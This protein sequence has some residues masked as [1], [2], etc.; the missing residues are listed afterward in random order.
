MRCIGT[1][2]VGEDVSS[3]AEAI[4]ASFDGRLIMAPMPGVARVWL[5]VP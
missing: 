3:C 1:R 5:A 4:W 2:L